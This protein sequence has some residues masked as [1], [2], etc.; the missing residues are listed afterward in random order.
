M[1]CTFYLYTLSIKRTYHFFRAML[2]TQISYSSYEAHL[3]SQRVAF[4][5]K[6]KNV[7]QLQKV[8]CKI[9]TEIA[10]WEPPGKAAYSEH[11]IAIHSISMSGYVTAILAFVHA[12][13]RAREASSFCDFGKITSCY[14]I[15][16]LIDSSKHLFFE[17]CL[18]RSTIA[19]LCPIMIHFDALDF[20]ECR[21]EEV[22]FCF[23]FFWC[24]VYIFSW[25]PESRALTLFKDVSMRTK[26]ALMP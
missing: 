15:L 26:K 12:E 5:K 9:I 19:N 13:L 20:S 4:V 25:E 21:S 1:S 7:V 3:K 10:R 23:C 8:I 22:L 6:E 17:M 18:V 24:S 2:W 11:S 16:L 14:L